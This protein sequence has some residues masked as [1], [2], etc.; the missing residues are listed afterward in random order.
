MLMWMVAWN[1]NQS[2]NHT[3]SRSSSH[4][5]L[6][7]CLTITGFAKEIDVLQTYINEF[8]NTNQVTLPHEGLHC[9]TP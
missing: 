3:T 1:Q 6:I 5:R 8:G 7:R 9:I 4:S 2:Q